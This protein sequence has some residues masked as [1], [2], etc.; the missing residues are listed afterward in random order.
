M[1]MEEIVMN[2][3]LSIQN[4]DLIATKMNVELFNEYYDILPLETNIE[5]LLDI[6]EPETYSLDNTAIDY[7]LLNLK[8]ISRPGLARWNRDVYKLLLLHD[9]DKIKTFINSQL[10]NKEYDIEDKLFIQTMIQLAVKTSDRKYIS[11]VLT[12]LRPYIK[13]LEEEEK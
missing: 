9:K 13:L 5:V 3:V 8:G 6:Y 1:V 7:V 4:N 12:Q 11:N 10:E 2:L